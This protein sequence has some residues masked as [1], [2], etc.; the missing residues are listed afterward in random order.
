MMSEAQATEIVPLAFVRVHRRPPTPRELAWFRAQGRHEGLYGSWEALNNW[1]AVQAK[2]GPPCGSDA[3]EH[4]D[5]HS[6]GSEYSWC[7]RTYPDPVSGCADMIRIASSPDTIK[8]IATGNIDA[9]CEV[10][11]ANHYFEAKANDYAIA[12]ER[13]YT[14]SAR[15]LHEPI[16]LHR[17]NAREHRSRDSGSGLAFALFVMGGELLTLRM[18]L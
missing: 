4:L 18:M 17:G 2:Q 8:A 9:V 6:D 12:I 13:N 10:L 5:H 14:L 16:V 7:Y 3:V 15:S 1:G 11:R